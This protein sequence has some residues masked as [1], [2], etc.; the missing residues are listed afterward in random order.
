[1]KVVLTFLPQIVAENKFELWTSPPLAL[2]V[3]AA[4]LEKDGHL[5]RV[6]DPCEYFQFNEKSGLIENSYEFLK[7]EI[8][9]YDMVCFSSNTFNWG[10]T[11]VVVNKLSEDYP[12]KHYVCGGLHPS[13]FDKHALEVSKMNFVLRGEGERSIR[14]LANAL[15]GKFAFEDIKGL[16]YYKDGV[17]C[18]NED[19]TPLTVAELEASPIPDFKYLTDDNP[20][21]A[22]PV[23]SSRGCAFSC[24]FCSIPNRHNWRGISPD[25]IIERIEVATSSNKIQ[26]REKEHIQILFSDDCL[27][28]NTERAK[29]LMQKLYEK[30][31]YNFSYFFEV[32]I[33]NIISDNLMES[34]PAGIVHSMQIGVEAGY[35]EGLK[36][37]KKV[38]TIEQ[39]YQGLD[40]IYANGFTEKCF[41]SFIIGFPWETEE[42]VNQ[43][44]DTVERILRT[45]NIFISLNWLVFLPSDLWKEREKYRIDVDESMYDAPIWMMDKDIFYKTRPRLSHDAVVRIEN[46]IHDLQAHFRKLKFAF[47]EE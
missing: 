30:Y 36:L 6:I 12:D 45:Y 19:V 14:Q 25:K 20:Y 8:V 23:E 32:R 24:A 3:L 28:I 4:C 7:K 42:N 10:F 15:E 34:I 40:I 26:S 27:T 29:E 11:R 35:D 46:R 17:I 16:T 31:E 2:Y 44:L 37:V 41:L 39:L 33:S 13:L 1:M 9:D 22:I 43:T 47:W 38:L 18:R 21:Y 5:I